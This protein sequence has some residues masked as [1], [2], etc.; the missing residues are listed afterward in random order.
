MRT[1]NPLRELLKAGKPS[2]GTRL[3]ISWPTIIELVGYSA[4]FDYVEITAEYSPYD[5]YTLENQG[6]AIE[7]FAH[8][9][10]MIKIGQEMRMHLAV[11]AMNSG[12]QNLLF[13]D[14]RSPAD[15]QECVRAVRAEAPE[16][17][18]LHGVGQGR[19]V[20]VVLEVGSPVFVQSTVDAVVALMIE[21]KQ[22]IE[23]LPAILS[24][25]GVDMVQ[26]GP[27]DYAMSIGLAE[28][29]AH[30][31]V[32][33]AERYMIETALRMGVTPRAEIRQP[34]AADR[35]LEMGVRHFCLGTDVRILFEWFKG[36]GNMMRTRLES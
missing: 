24:V 35:Y 33:E 8:L 6:R 19:D 36:Q 2:L 34:Q 10:G 5:L 12:I 15:A 25:K 14:I 22:A 27:A 30:P 20:G 32:L 1:K 3:Q 13:A 18:G 11:R 26:F 16:I 29:R 21:K 28:N 17:D 31:A 9:S 23:D 4:A 7:L